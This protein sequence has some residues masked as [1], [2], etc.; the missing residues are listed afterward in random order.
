ML[1]CNSRFYICLFSSCTKMF[2]YEATFVPVG[3]PRGWRRAA[4]DPPES[5]ALQ[6][7]DSPGDSRFNT[8]HLR[9]IGK[10]I[11]PRGQFV[12]TVVR[13]PNEESRIG[14]H[15]RGYLLLSFFFQRRFVADQGRIDSGPSSASARLPLA[16]PVR[17][18]KTKRTRG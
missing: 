10:K 1:L 15:R 12:S 16:T 18:E 8:P 17:G 5:G 11:R 13:W 2:S 9:L 14:D 4:L 3:G 7:G 6:P